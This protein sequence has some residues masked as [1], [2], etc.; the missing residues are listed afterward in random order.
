MQ[1]SKSVIHRGA[2]SKLSKI[3]RLPNEVAVI[4]VFITMLLSLASTGYIA[5]QFEIRPSK[6]VLNREGCIHLVQVGIE[7]VPLPGSDMCWV[8]CPFRPSRLDDGGR[9]WVGEREIKISESQL[10]GFS[11]RTSTPW[12]VHQWFLIG[13]EILSVLLVLFSMWLTRKCLRRDDQ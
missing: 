2:K 4:L 10:I 8:E 1:S 5:G 13:L 12:T 9:I 6:L 3:E 11:P 7:P